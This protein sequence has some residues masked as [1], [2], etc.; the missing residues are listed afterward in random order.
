MEDHAEPARPLVS[1]ILPTYDR[2]GFVQRAVEYFRRQDY[3]AR[4]LVIVDDGTDPVDDLTGDRAGTSIR[5]VR[6]ADR[7]TIGAKRNIGCAA[8]TG[9]LVLHWDDDD[10]MPSDRISRQVSAFLAAP[11]DVSGLRTM[12]YLDVRTGECWRYTYPA[13]LGP[14]VATPTFCYRRAYGLARPFPDRRIGS[15]GEWLRTEPRPRVG[16]LTDPTLYLGLLHAGNTARKD[17]A[18]SW[19]RRISAAE[20]QAMTGPDWAALTTAG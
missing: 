9:S 15:G 12:P 16:M 1:C 6:L 4:E 8:A 2:R 19:W 7:Q 14:W 5:Y 18:S 13:R 17:T 3:P 10:W 20:V 11:V